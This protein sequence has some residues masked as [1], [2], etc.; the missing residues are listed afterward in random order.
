MLYLQHATDPVTWLSPELLF[1]AP[2]WLEPDERG[3][4]V[5]PAMRWIPIVTAMQVAVDMLGGEAV[6]ARH[7]H[8]FGDVAVIGWQQ[9]TGEAG[10]DAVAVARIQAE[11]ESYAP[12]LPHQE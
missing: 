1:Q 8:N 6:P 11:I 9:I 5:S 10:L 7:G 3:P 2:E 4:D 12:I